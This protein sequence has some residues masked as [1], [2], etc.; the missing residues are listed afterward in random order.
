M[1]MAANSAS[2]LVKKNAA[3]SC[4]KSMQKMQIQQELMLFIVNEPYKMVLLCVLLMCNM[5][6]V[7][8]C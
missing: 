8:H 1:L 2:V 3:T 5:K 6:I 7:V 4:N